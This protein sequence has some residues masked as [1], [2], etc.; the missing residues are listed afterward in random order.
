VSRRRQGARAGW[1]CIV[2]CGDGH[3][4]GKLATLTYQPEDVWVPDTAQDFIDGPESGAGQVIG[5]GPRVSAGGRP[6]LRGGRIVGQRPGAM[7]QVRETTPDGRT[8]TRLRCPQ[9]GR[10][11]PLSW[12]TLDHVVA[13]LYEQRV[14]HIELRELEAIVK[15]SSREAGPS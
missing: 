6:R 13:R 12:P 3:P 8:K 1:R 7:D 4:S 15:R 14:P 2:V 9:C 10:D 11:V 5:K